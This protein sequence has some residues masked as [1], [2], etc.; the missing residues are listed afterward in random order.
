MT[1]LGSYRPQIDQAKER[2]AAAGEKIAAA[3]RALEMARAD[4]G[5]AQLEQ[6]AS[7][8]LET[9][10]A[11]S[12]LASELHLLLVQQAAGISGTGHRD[13]VFDDPRVVGQLEQ[14]AF[15]SGPIG[16]MELGQAIDR[17]QLVAM[18]QTGDWGSELMAAAGQVTVGN[19]GR[20]GTFY[21]IAPQPRR[22]IRL[23]DLIPTL[24]MSGRSFDYLQAQGSLDTAT[25]IAEGAVKPQAEADFVDKE[26]VAKTVAHWVKGKRQQLADVPALQQTVERR[27]TYGVLRRVESQVLAGDG[28]G[29]NLSGIL[30][31]AGIGGVPF[32]S[33]NPLTDH[34]LDGMVDVIVA[35]S[36]PNGVILNPADWASMLKARATANGDRLDS[37]GA[38]AAQP[39]TIWGLPAIPS[40]V[41]PQGQALVGDFA[42][43]CTLFIREGVNVR[44]SDSDQDDFVR[45][46]LTTLAETRVA[47]A[48][49]QATA[50]SLVHLA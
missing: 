37:P 28:N 48:V 42:N 40:T 49:W 5:D 50:F 6:A 12:E 35:D 23:L 15:S 9:A 39:S 17:D 29:E 30:D 11:E 31:Q 19:E 21:G 41:I 43:G 13:N 14:L 44:I 26:A 27:L 22:R 38:F 45:N 4:G 10:R 18:V 32:V 20:S 25:E 24:P 16:R 33:A 36:E 34:A 1:L 3:R 47:L 8:A 7:T 46:V 2:K